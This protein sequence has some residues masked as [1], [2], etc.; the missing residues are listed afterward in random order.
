[1][2]SEEVAINWK[3]SFKSLAVAAKKASESFM[4]FSKRNHS[5]VDVQE[6]RCKPANRQ[7][8]FENVAK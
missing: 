3:E 8:A 4:K 2:N 5:E 1:M 7:T 6:E